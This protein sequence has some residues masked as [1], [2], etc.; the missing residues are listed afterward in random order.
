M[1]SQGGRFTPAQVAAVM[2]EDEL[3]RTLGSLGDAAVIRLSSRDSELLRKVARK[4]PPKK[5]TQALAD[6]EADIRAG[7]IVVNV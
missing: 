4:A 2:I 5:L 6:L 7:R 3:E 1:A